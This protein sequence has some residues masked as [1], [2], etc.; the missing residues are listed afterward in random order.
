MECAAYFVAAAALV[1]CVYLY[2]NRKFVKPL[3]RSNNILYV[4]DGDDSILNLT[5]IQVW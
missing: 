4:P 1:A 5:C 3:R 2:L